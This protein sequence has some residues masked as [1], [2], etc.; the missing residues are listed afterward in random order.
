MLIGAIDQGSTSTKGAVFDERG[1]VVASAL[2]PVARLVEE[3]RVEHDPLALLG[4]VEE[5]LAQLE[6]EAPFAALA[7][8]G[9]RS[10]CLVWERESGRPL[11]P[12]VS[13]Q[14]RRQ[15]DDEAQFRE[16]AAQIARRTGLRLSP[17]YA[18]LKLRALLGGLPAGRRRADRGEIVAG[19]LD[20]FLVQRLTGRAS[21]EPGHAGRTLLYDL[22]GDRWDPWLCDRFGV[23]L[24][25]LP[26]LLPS[27]GARGEWRGVPLLA[28][29]GDQ[30]AALLGLGGWEAGVLAAHFGT[31][32][33]VLGSTGTRLERVPGLLSAVVAQIAEERRFQLEG[34]VN[35]AGSAVDWACAL[36]GTTLE[37]YAD[38]DLDPER[39]P[40]IFPAFA[41]AA[42]PWWR[43]EVGA[44]ASGLQMSTSAADLAA[45][46]LAG[47]AQRVLDCV[48]AMTGAGLDGEALRVSGRLTRRRGL[49]GLLADLGQRPVEVAGE[50]ESGVRGAARLARSV[51]TGERRSLAEPPRVAFRR[52]PV[53]APERAQRVRARWRCFVE[54]VLALPA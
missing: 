29:A 21:T 40:W 42:A 31:G 9:Q 10:T 38:P 36:T 30:Q 41:G 27:A 39:L 47:V 22:E 11:T 34:S 16:D 23:P 54:T 53:W 5:V 51:L 26:E 4:S 13:W 46:V 18:A 43:P 20:A 35:S 14:D 24:A 25:A 8:T 33:F 37:S 3:A 52:E 15:V 2:V 44:A 6:R 19:T 1:A 50:E 49:V 7:L 48:E 17:H 32:A 12:A 28:L 45:G